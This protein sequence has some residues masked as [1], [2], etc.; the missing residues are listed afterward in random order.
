MKSYLLILPITIT[1]AIFF[2]PITS[3]S[4]STGSVGGKTGS[5]TDGASCTACHYA[6]SGTGAT[7]TT[8]I[9]PSGYIP[10]QVYTITANIQEVGK[11]KFGFEISAEE[12]NFGSAKTGSFMITNSSETKFVNNNTAITHKAGGTSGVNSKN[13]S[14]DWEAPNAGTGGVT[15]YGAFLGTNGDG[16]NSGD[17]YHQATLT[18]NEE[19]INSSENISSENQIIFNSSNKTI[20][21]LNK[22][23]IS[24]YSLEGKLMLS[25]NK[26]YTNLSHFSKGTY[27]IKSKNKTKKIILN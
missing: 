20:E 21:V 18:I 3:N 16:S 2:Y 24:V 8:N 7:I 27:I 15:F 4:N 13:W 5:P 11:F 1:L 12:A 22:S 6:G 26:K 25:S 9:P 23:A 17:T 19:I 10:N 14:M